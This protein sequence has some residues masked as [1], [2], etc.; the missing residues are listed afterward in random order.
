[1]IK[2]LTILPEDLKA[3]RLVNSKKYI[4]E[5]SHYIFNCCFVKFY[6]SLPKISQLF[7]IPELMRGTSTNKPLVTIHSDYRIHLKQLAWFR[8]GRCL[9]LVFF[10]GLLAHG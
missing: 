6:K 8:K 9:S 7:T 3:N 2:L 5:F 1:M 4:I 10:T